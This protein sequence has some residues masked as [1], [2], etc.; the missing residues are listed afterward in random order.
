M[1]PRTLTVLLPLVALILFGCSSPEPLPIDFG[2]VQCTACKMLVA[3]TRF[4]AEAVSIT[5]K[6]F[7]FDAPE[8]MLGWYLAEEQIKQDDVHSLWVSDHAAPATLIDARTALFLESEELHS[9]MSMNV[10]AFSTE[11][12]LRD[13]L[14]RY[15]GTRRSYDDVVALAEDYK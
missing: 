13:A 2:N 8:C 1:T 15:G 9:P 5:G 11:A 10:A 12:A 14:A 6:V 7:V 4:G 3:D